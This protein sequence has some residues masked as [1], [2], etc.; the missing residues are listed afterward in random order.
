MPVNLEAPDAKRLY[1]V[2]GVELGIAMAGVRK[3]NRRDLTV[4]T[5]TG[6]NTLALA[7]GAA[8]QLAQAANTQV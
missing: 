2:Q 5:L 1:P 6:V 8:P 4:V 3:A 7:E